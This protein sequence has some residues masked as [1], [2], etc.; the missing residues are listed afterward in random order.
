MK[1]IILMGIISLL[2]LT[3][4]TLL[5]YDFLP[6]QMPIHWDLSERRMTTPT[7]MSFWP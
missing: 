3:A 2:I 4:A 6:A 5:T 7:K 1:K